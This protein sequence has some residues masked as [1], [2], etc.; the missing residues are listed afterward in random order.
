MLFACHH[1]LTVPLSNA[2]ISTG[3]TKWFHL[4]PAAHHQVDQIH[5]KIWQDA[6][7]NPHSSIDVADRV[8]KKV[9][10]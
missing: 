7:E 5:F 6:W 3:P 1:V 9:L 8:A 4:T 10:R 2:I